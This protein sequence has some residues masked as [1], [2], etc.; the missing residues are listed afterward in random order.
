[1]AGLEPMYQTLSEFYEKPFGNPFPKRDEF[2]K[3]YE[4]FKL[5]IVVLNYAVLD[6]SYYIHLRIPSESSPGKSYDVVIQFLPQSD[7]VKNQLSLDNYVVQFFSNSPSFVYKYAVLY[8]NYGYMIDALQSKLDPEYANKLPEK[9]N[10]DMDLTYEKSLYFAV[11]FLLERKAVYLYKP[12]LKFQKKKDFKDLVSSIEDNKS[13]LKRSLSDIE[14][15]AEEE[16]KIDIKKIEKQVQKRLGVRDNNNQKIK[17]SRSTAKDSNGN[18]I[19]AMTKKPKKT[20]N[21]KI[22]PK[23]ST[24]KKP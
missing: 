22:T 13:S 16:G 21:A 18:R 2:N 7:V 1:M 4:R 15:E 20:P 9:T 23:K 11:K 3:K 14:K 19:F 10:K 6:D 8:K 24:R 5:L 12:A 17:P